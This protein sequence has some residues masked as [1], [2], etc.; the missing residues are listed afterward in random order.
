MPSDALTGF[1]ILV[2][3]DE[4][5]LRRHIAATLER[6]G[7]DVAQADSVASARQ[8][9]RDLGFDF[10]LVDVN[11]PDGSGTD[12]LGEGVFG[13]GTGVIMMTAMGAV[14]GA[15][16]AMKLGALD[17]LTKPFEPEALA[18]SLAR[19]RQQ[20]QAVRAAEHRR[21]DAPISSFF[22]GASLAGLEGQLQRILTADRRL[23]EGGATPSPVLI[24][25]ETGTGKTTIARW[26][27]GQGP[28]TSAPLIE[29]NC[30]AI[31]ES[32][33]ESELF[34][35]EKGAFTDARSARMGLFEAA[36]GGTL[37]LDE[38]ASLSLPLQAKLLTVL[39]DRRVRRVGGNRD[40][41]VDVRVIAAVNRDL[42]E[43]VR[44][45]RFREDLF[46]RLDL[47]RVV[48][49]PLRD[50]GEDILELADALLARLSRRHR[51]PTRG[52]SDL[53]RRRVMGYG[54]P[55]NVRELAHEL[56]RALVFEDGDGLNLDQLI[57][58]V[59]HPPES[60]SGGMAASA[61]ASAPAAD[62]FNV[63]Y[64][65][66]ESGFSLEEAILRLIEHALAETQGN[67]SKAA[68]KLGVSR[69]YLR[70]R[71]GG[72]KDGTKA[73]ESRSVDEMGAVPQPEANRGA[74]P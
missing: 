73:G 30:A 64:R 39:E 22:F 7:A 70:Y 9:V 33:A 72:W 28:R 43:L 60:R 23:H 18:L 14:E 16:A 47:F 41:P 65:F 2:V 45:G 56:E 69:D 52:L 3:D 49:T 5:L 36:N 8:L 57:G 34:G 4:P 29:A 71:L 25:G 11:L 51:L 12:L 37:F 63:S 17:Y 20:R 27:H 15:V 61:D 54:W 42:R 13:S 21:A 68:R 67:V 44:E 38:M 40:I 19:A 46:H 31:P 50:R 10:A 55:G 24:Q 6:L 48:L 62:W 1:H 58:A 53:G 66:P 26:I 35:H 74:S 59:G 32:L